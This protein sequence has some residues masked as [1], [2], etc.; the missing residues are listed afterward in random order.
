[1]QPSLTLE[2]PR[3]P[4]A[5]SSGS[6]VI[7]YSRK[8]LAAREELTVIRASKSGMPPLCLLE[9]VLVINIKL[10]E[11]QLDL[12][13]SRDEIKSLASKLVTAQQG[14]AEQQEAITKLMARVESLS[15]DNEALR[16]GSQGQELR[17]AT[18]A[19]RLEEERARSAALEAVLEAER[20]KNATLEA[21]LKEQ[22]ASTE[23]WQSQWKK[24]LKKAAKIDAQVHNAL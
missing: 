1:M 7:D 11:T 6:D 21:A 24:V 13:L 12:S 5:V 19:W 15:R 3:G 16:S 9:A 10:L 18:S 4:T 14:N 23:L 22:K 17:L 2:T 8:L 20:A